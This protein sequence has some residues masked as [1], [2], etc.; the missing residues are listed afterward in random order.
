MTSVIGQSRAKTPGNSVPITR[1]NSAGFQILLGLA[2][3]TA[4]IAMLSPGSEEQPLPF[5]QADKLV[6]LLTFMLLG[7]FADAGW[8]ER[9]FTPVKYLPLLCYGIGIEWLQQYVPF[10]EFSLLDFVANAAG[11]A[12]YGLALLPLLRHQGIR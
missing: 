6:H 4:S 1:C 8:P 11:L 12:L 5:W 7:F 2:L 3:L 10:R 9:G